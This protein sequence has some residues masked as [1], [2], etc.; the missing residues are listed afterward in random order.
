MP[1]G[2]NA[3]DRGWRQ[4]NH[5]SQPIWR[6]KKVLL[7]RSPRTA[8]ETWI[9]SLCAEAD[10]TVKHTFDEVVDALR[11]QRFDLVVSDQGD[12]LALERAAVTQ[13]ASA[14]LE[15]LGQG[16]CMVDESGRLLYAN[17]AMRAYPSDLLTQ[18]CQSCQR[19]LLGARQ[20][21]AKDP[22]NPQQLAHRFPLTAGNDQY[23]E[24]TA[25]P[26]INEQQ[27]ES[28]VVA[29]VWD[30]TRARRLQKKIDAIDAAGRELAELGTE[31]A[32]KKSIDDRI[33]LLEETVTQHLQRLLHFHNFAVLLIDK[34]TNRLEIVFQHGMAPNSLTYDLYVSTEGSGISGY[35]A[36]TGKS[37][38]CGDIEK[39]PR[40]LKGL[41]SAK[42]SLTVPLRQHD[43]VIGVF[44]IES[45]RL[46][47]F[48]E[49]D[50]QFAEILARYIAMALHTLEL[51]IGERYQMTGQFADEVSHEIAG[52]LNDI[53]TEAAT[54]KEE[55]IGNDDLRRRLDLI[56]DN[57][58]AIKQSI[59]DV[60]CPK[61]GLLGRRDEA[62][63]VDPVLNGKRVLV[64]DDEEIIRE[65][66]AGVLA[67][68]GCVVDTASDGAAA[69]SLFESRPYDLVLA[70]IKMPHKN[71]YEI[72]AAVKDKSPTTPVML[73]TGFGY[74][75]NHSIVRAR[76]EGLAGVL[77]K[78]FKIDQLLADLRRALTAP[79]GQPA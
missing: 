62:V 29:V 6:G 30:V 28:H 11:T 19:V 8:R 39:D 31:E 26:V 79:S 60:A 67:K 21:T 22:Q 24:V 53:L 4:P 10:V 70:D 15:S 17:A 66:I 5:M 18:T 77:F 14:T 1:S 13:Q 41:E 73:M 27:K 72:F 45:D 61:G 49:E 57:V 32:A 23:F 40:Y 46:G 74:D 48:N 78:P 52:P 12:F 64:A 59:R 3:A 58:T 25:T 37:Y 71:G 76:R 51:L 16:V 7:F 43:K 56:C 75:P 20:A 35:V 68:R 44:N 47:A 38:I 9:D 2:R 55:Y 65:T 42:S 36:A 33:R 54:I 69:M 34:K 63:E 50:K